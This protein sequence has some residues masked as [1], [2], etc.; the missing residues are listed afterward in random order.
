MIRSFCALLL[1]L[2]AFVALTSFQ[3]GGAISER[4]QAI[5]DETVR[6]KVERFSLRKQKSC[7]DKIMKRAEAMADSILL[8][9][10]KDSLLVS[11]LIKPDIP[12]K[13]LPPGLIFPTPSSAIAPFIDPDTFLSSY[14]RSDSLLQVLDS[15]SMD[16]TLLDSLRFLQQLPGAKE[17][18]LPDS[19]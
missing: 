16:S 19:Q 6:E 2:S 13:P 3:N 17:E 5:I 1:V 4:E 10:A 18:E 14:H 11:Q 15:M 7:R 8:A 12:M 9:E